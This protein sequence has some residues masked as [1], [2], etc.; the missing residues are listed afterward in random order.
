MLFLRLFFIK[1]FI[2]NKL[3]SIHFTSISLSIYIYI[4]IPRLPVRTTVIYTIFTLCLAA[5]IGV[6]GGFCVLII[7]KDHPMKQGMQNMMKGNPGLCVCVCVCVLVCVCACVYVCVKV[8]KSVY[9]C[10]GLSIY[11]RACMCVCICMCV[12]VCMYVCACMCV[13]VCMYVC[14]CM[15]VCMC[16]LRSMYVYVKVY[17]TLNLTRILLQTI[18]NNS[19]ELS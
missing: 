19:I 8:C 16:V 6:L 5:Y 10:K 17:L 18:N 9:A 2:Q 1:I 4:N 13:Y 11:V 3:Y 14:A 12:C 15:C 7:D